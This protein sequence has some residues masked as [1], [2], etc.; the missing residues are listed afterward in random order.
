MACTTE[1]ADDSLP[2][3]LAEATHEN[4]DEFSSETFKLVGGGAG[5]AGVGNTRNVREHE[6]PISSSAS[7]KEAATKR[8]G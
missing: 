2:G 4:L 5:G 6:D 3:K 8:R 7:S 1:H